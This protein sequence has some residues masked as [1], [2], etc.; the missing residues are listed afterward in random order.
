MSIV[1]FQV[2]SESG[3]FSG[4]NLNAL[5][6]NG[7]VLSWDLNN[8]AGG[9]SN[10]FDG[11][12]KATFKVQY[13][14]AVA[15]AAN[16]GFSLWLLRSVDGG[17]TW[18]DGGP[19]NIPVRAPDGFIPVFADTNMHSGMCDLFLYPGHWKVLLQNTGTGQA[20]TTSSSDNTASLTPYTDQLV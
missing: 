16:T 9:G 20:L 12:E 2:G 3:I 8:T 10:S 17:N 19:S 1:K 4:S 14:F 5:A 6:N 7:A 15:P 13:K 11:Y 18:E